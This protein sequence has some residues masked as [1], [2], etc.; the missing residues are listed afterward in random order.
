M[1]QYFLRRVI[2]SIPVIIGVSILVFLLIHLIPGD[3]AT[4]MLGE[5][6]TQE[7]V[8]AL[9]ERL[10]LDKPLYEQYLIWVGNLLQGDLGNTVR[11]NIPVKDE[12]ANRFPATIELSIWALTIATT[13]GLPVGIVSAI[14]RNSLID[15]AS[16]FGA[17]FG[18]SIPI[19]VLGLLLIFFVGVELRWL[20]FVG[21]LSS[22]LSVERVTGLVTIDA[23]IERDWAALKDAVEHLILPAITLATIPLAIIARIT[24]SAMLEV[25]NQDYIRTARAKGLKSRQVIMRHGFRN[26]MLPI[27]TIIGLQLGTLLSG[28]VLTETIYSWPGVG[29]WLFDS[30]VA[31]DYAI[32]QSMTLLIAMIYIV[33]NFAVDVLY[34]FIDP[35]IRY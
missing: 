10:G 11:G 27:V 18:V 12:I 33:V 8:A 29:K 4:A 16:M 34:A 20:P 35:R 3:P 2:E 28:A 22:G 1:T 24:R 21:R 5:R 6:A 13:I 14:K 15:T 7:N 30:I 32:V 25:L 26:A 31:R 19:F 23:L 17:L 9:R